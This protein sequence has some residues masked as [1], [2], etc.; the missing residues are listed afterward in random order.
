[1]SDVRLPLLR[2]WLDEG[3][4][5]DVEA[6]R[7]ELGTRADASDAEVAATVV[8]SLGR[9]SLLKASVRP[10]RRLDD[11]HS[12][13]PAP[14]GA[15]DSSFLGR[16]GVAGEQGM[17]VDR[18]DDLR[19]LIAVVRGGTLVQR[20]AAVVRIGALL[21]HGRQ[22][23]EVTKEAMVMLHQLRD[24]ELLYERAK[25]R[26]TLP[27]AQG[28]RARTE[29]EQW[30]A[31]LKKV[32]A[33]VA[34][35]WDGESRVEPILALPG[36]QRAMLLARVR[37]LP[38]P[39]VAHLSAVIEGCD[40]ATDEAGRMALLSSLRYAGDRRLVPSLSMLLATAPADLAIEAARV[41][42]RIDDPRVRPA[43]LAAFDRSLVDSRRA[44]LVG[45]LALQGD[46]RGCGYVR[47]LLETADAH[48]R[49]A[50]LEALEAV[51]SSEDSESVAAGLEE[52]DT[53]LLARTVRTLARVGDRRVLPGLLA[54]RERTSVSA[55]WAEAEDAIAAIRA[56]LELR[57]EEPQTG[58]TLVFKVPAAPVERKTVTTLARLQARRDL[59]VGSLWLLLGF[60]GRAMAR[61][62]AAALRRPGWTPPLV[63]A[64]MAYIG[65]EEF[66]R[67]LTAF[68]QAI[69]ADRS[70]L[71]RNAI[72]I[73]AI[74][75]AFLRRAEEMERD[76]RKDIARGL[77]G[78]VLALDL[79]RAPGALRFELVRRQEALRREA[80]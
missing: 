41:L 26:E 62:D 34:S 40:G 14:V 52:Q 17:R 46:Y 48:V 77:V 16:L 58:D 53:V 37:D 51:G 8:T 10:D 29:A 21:A 39:I 63:A 23:P 43:L 59:W 72:V 80:A 56:R 19:T 11:R 12:L 44:V 22:D 36:D 54:L 75:H 68:R 13:P 20:R 57:G 27:G 60:F 73:K 69:A 9:A 7:N 65:R 64:G 49:L 38:D 45:A 6:I 55:L 74:A 33:S 1:M 50:A 28:R 30:R 5:V 76:G 25:A 15:A 66:A 61:F 35:F 2:A 24:V 4:G 70:R 42:G 47:E 18:L 71:E 78:E 32:E 3:I 31:T 67:A 79:R